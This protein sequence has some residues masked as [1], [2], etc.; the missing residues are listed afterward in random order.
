MDPRYRDIAGEQIPAVKLPH[1]T[2][3]KV[4]AGEV[5]SAKG[6][7]RDI[8]IE[9]EYLDVT[10]PANSEFRHPPYKKQGLNPAELDDRQPV[11]EGRTGGLFSRSRLPS[12]MSSILSGILCREDFMHEAEWFFP[13]TGL[14]APTVSDLGRLNGIF[15]NGIARPPR[16]P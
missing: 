7:V 1:G 5:S 14:R 2:V 8:V 13:S 12:R 10:L 16:Q 11:S 3:I 6:R 9:P 15:P 4:I